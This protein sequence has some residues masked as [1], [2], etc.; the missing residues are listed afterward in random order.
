[1]PSSVRLG[2]PYS[3]GV[4][5]AYIDGLVTQHRIFSGKRDLHR[6]NCITV[7]TT[8]INTSTSLF[9]LSSGLSTPELVIA[10]KT[11]DL[12]PSIAAGDHPCGKDCED[13]RCGDGKH[14]THASR[15]EFA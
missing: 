13:G 6:W 12:H 5:V 11:T 10:V 15:S 2:P 1:M 3:F 8:H 4:A 14:G 7:L 9:I